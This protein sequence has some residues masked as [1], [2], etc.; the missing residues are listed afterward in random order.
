MTVTA[1]I[2]SPSKIESPFDQAKDG[3]KG[4][5]KGVENLKAAELS[6]HVWK[7][8]DLRLIP[9]L[10]LMLLFAFMDRCEHCSRSALSFEPRSSRSAMKPT[11]V[12]TE[13]QIMAPVGSI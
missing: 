1:T 3:I 4:H 7:K 12:C 10:A 5:S 13:I 6:K 9:I 8:V 2:D 11:S